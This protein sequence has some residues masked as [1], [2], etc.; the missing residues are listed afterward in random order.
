LRDYR[1]WI[2]SGRAVRTV[3]S[4]IDRDLPNFRSEKS[5]ISGVGAA[6]EVIYK[7]RV[8]RPRRKHMQG[9]KPWSSLVFVSARFSHLGVALNAWTLPF[10]VP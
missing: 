3:Q 6:Q 8:R 5:A 9:V 4:E 10:I 1:R 7:N 2:V